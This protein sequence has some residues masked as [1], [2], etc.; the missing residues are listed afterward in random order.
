[1][2]RFISVEFPSIPGALGQDTS[3]YL[4]KFSTNVMLNVAHVIA[5]E[6]FGRQQ[7]GLYR[8]WLSMGQV[9]DVRVRG[10]NPFAK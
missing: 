8:V 2:S 7:P 1:M 3:I 6:P 4:N 10:A 5:V 9:I